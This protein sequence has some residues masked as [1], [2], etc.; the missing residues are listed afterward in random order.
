[1]RVLDAEFEGKKS[2]H[3]PSSVVGRQSLAKNCRYRGRL[4]MFN[5]KDGR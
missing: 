5:D 3:K 1:L 2:N 4:L